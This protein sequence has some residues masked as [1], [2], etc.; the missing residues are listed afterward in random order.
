MTIN[1][2]RAYERTFAVVVPDDWKWDGQDEKF[3]VDPTDHTT[4]HISFRSSCHDAPCTV[5]DFRREFDK[6]LEDRI[7]IANANV[8]ENRSTP[9]ERQF[10]TKDSAHRI[11]LDRYWWSGETPTEYFG[12]TV[13][14]PEEFEPSRAAFEKAC[15]L[16]TV[17]K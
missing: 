1:K 15:D 11:A 6:D 12:C 14:T 13:V 3:Y 7:K 9:N 5:G 16:V 4:G 8:L 17:Q 2:G 10:V